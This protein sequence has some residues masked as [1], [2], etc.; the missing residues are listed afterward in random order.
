[1]SVYVLFLIHTVCQTRGV[2]VGIRLE[3]YMATLGRKGTSGPPWVDAI[4]GSRVITRKRRHGGTRR[5]LSKAA[6]LFQNTTTGSGEAGRVPQLR[7]VLEERPHQG[8]SG[9]AIRLPIG[10]ASRRGGCAFFATAA[11]SPCLATAWQPLR[12]R[13]NAQAPDKPTLDH[14]Q[15]RRNLQQEPS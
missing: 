14:Q 4:C 15:L 8:S 10:I 1:M 9:G 12:R 5:L 11:S 7:K 13:P 6:R 3:G 2:A